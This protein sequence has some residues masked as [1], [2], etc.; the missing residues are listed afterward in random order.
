MEPGE[1][2]G[3]TT[4]A[5]VALYSS[6]VQ[7]YFI[8]RSLSE[9]WGITAGADPVGF[10]LG[11]PLGDVL[12]GFLGAIFFD[13]YLTSLLLSPLIPSSLLYFPVIP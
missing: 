4:I 5:L 10:T 3:G 7:P 1:G 9:I 12:K 2:R 11:D 6:R 8:K 13:W